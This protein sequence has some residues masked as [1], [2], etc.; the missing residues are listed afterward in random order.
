[1]ILSSS[2]RAG[3]AVAPVA[4]LPGAAA[5]AASDPVFAALADERAKFARWDVVSEA[6]NQAEDAWFKVSDQ[7]PRRILLDFDGAMS[8]DGG[9]VYSEIEKL[10]RKFS[11]LERLHAGESAEL[12]VLD[13]RRREAIAELTRRI[14]RRDA[15]KERRNLP[16][17]EEAAA[18]AL[19]DWCEAERKVL[20]TAPTTREGAIALA[21][22]AAR[23]LEEDGQDGKHVVPALRN[24]AAFLG[25]AT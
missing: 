6:R 17:V 4:V 5:P 14:E 8:N 25:A 12:A 10:D 9:W 2:R 23:M 15:E 21:N 20:A 19:S 3:L 24:L 18:D 13:K 11:L 16:A 1:M 7:F 22:F